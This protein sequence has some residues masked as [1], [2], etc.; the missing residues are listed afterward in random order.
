MMSTPFPKRGLSNEKKIIFYKRKEQ[1]KK[2][3][4]KAAAYGSDWY[5]IVSKS[6]TNC[7]IQLESLRWI[8]IE[9]AFK[10]KRTDA[11]RDAKSAYLHRYEKLQKKSQSI[12]RKATRHSKR[13]AVLLEA[14]TSNIKSLQAAYVEMLVNWFPKDTR[15]DR[16]QLASDLAKTDGVRTIAGWCE[17]VW[18]PVVPGWIN[19]PDT[20]VAHIV[21]LSVGQ[22][23]MTYLFGED[24]KWEINTAKNGMWLPP[25]VRDMFH[26]RE[27]VI[28]PVDTTK[29]PLEWKMLVVG[30]E[31][32]WDETA[33]W[34]VKFGDLHEKRVAFHESAQPRARYLYFHYLCA[35]IH[36]SRDIRQPNGSAADISELSRAW[37]SNASYI[38]KNVIAAFVRQL[39][40]AIPAEA[41]KDI[42]RK[43]CTEGISENE[44]EKMVA[45]IENLD[46]DSEDQKDY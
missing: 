18:S 28:V 9:A 12:R 46:F 1:E 38:C 14:K 39:R 42:R 36:R 5:W 41:L 40:D 44:A 32:V 19:K 37:G 30:L 17:Q 4:R 3:E 31:V 7:K 43:R 6:I 11:F 10:E 24:A 45:S 22:A 20:K 16:N 26:K 35:M 29:E 27:L 21:P 8:R 25:K 15:R 34:I 33:Y 23:A 13:D 2:E